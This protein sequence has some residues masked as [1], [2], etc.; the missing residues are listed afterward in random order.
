MAEYLILEFSNLSL[1][2][3]ALD[4]INISSLSILSGD[5]SDEYKQ[6]T[7]TWDII[8][9]SPDNTYYF[10]SPAGNTIFNAGYQAL[11]ASSINFV[12]KILPASWIPSDNPELL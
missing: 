6:I 7:K 2:Q 10:S 8:R 9:E 1:A 11:S 5:E 12:E 3:S 4:L